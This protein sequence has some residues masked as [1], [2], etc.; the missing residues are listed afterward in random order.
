MITLNMYEE[1]EDGSANC[2]INMDKQDVEHLINFAVVKLLEKGIKE[3]EELTPTTHNVNDE[4]AIVISSLK[5]QLVNSYTPISQHT[6]D[7]EVRFRIR[8][9]CKDLLRYYMIPSEAESYIKQIES[10]HE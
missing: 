3:G 2:V 1:N 5:R 9:C 6:E 8:Q 7:E 10:I 4:D